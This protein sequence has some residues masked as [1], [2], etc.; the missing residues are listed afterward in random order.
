MFLFFFLSLTEIT[1]FST[2]CNGISTGD[3]EAELQQT[4]NEF[5]FSHIGEKDYSVTSPRISCQPGDEVTVTGDVFYIKGDA[6]FQIIPYDFNNDPDWSFQSYPVVDSPG[7]YA[8]YTRKWIIPG[9][10][11]NFT[12]RFVGSN[13]T[14]F[15]FKSIKWDIT[16]HYDAPTIRN[17]ELENSNIKLTYDTLLLNMTIHDK[18]TQRTWTQRRQTIGGTTI[19]LKTTSSSISIDTITQDNLIHFNIELLEDGFRSTVALDNNNSEI[20]PPDY[21]F[22]FISS[23]GDRIVLPYCEGIT[24]PVDLTEL[25]GRDEFYYSIYS[26]S[27]AFVGQTNDLSSMIII[28]ETPYDSSVAVVRYN[29]EYLYIK[30][31]FSLE[32]GRFSYPRKLRYVF[33]EGNHVSI[34]KR[35]RKYAQEKGYLVPFTEKIK[36]RPNVDKLIGAVNVWTVGSFNIN[37]IKLYTEM[38][39]LGNR[40]NIIIRWRINQ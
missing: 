14:N 17:V 11:R 33:L 5:S 20:L 40:T 19:N 23:L 34:A 13:I 30:P 4:D 18:T 29:E 28:F 27:M 7:G 2:W 38:Q 12:F 24:L 35:Y 3:C 39:S 36:T 22:P 10:S 21:P 8:T 15:K 37:K 32:K 31:R 25:L 26:L 16:G 6:K 1:R 9:N